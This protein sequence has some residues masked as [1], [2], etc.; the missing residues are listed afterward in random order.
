MGLSPTYKF[1]RLSLSSGLAFLSCP[2]RY[3]LYDDTLLLLSPQTRHHE[4]VQR[5]VQVSD[6]E[7]GE[8]RYSILCVSH[9]ST[10]VVEPYILKRAVPRTLY[11]PLC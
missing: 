1:S 3:G 9:S 2:I 6:Q 11:L 4:E 8:A 7:G 10:W 5:A